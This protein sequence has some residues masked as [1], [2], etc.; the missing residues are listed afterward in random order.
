MRELRRALLALVVWW[1][2]GVA[3]VLIWP[4]QVLRLWRRYGDLAMAL[5]MS[6]VK[7]P[8]GQGVLSYWKR[9]LTGAR[10]QLIE[11]K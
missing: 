2:A 1:P 4:L 6:F 10:A 3:L 8:E 11:Y 5:S 9:R 7:L